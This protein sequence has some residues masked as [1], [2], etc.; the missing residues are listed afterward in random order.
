MTGPKLQGS[1]TL[2][3]SEQHVKNPLFYRTDGKAH[4]LRLAE[5][6]KHLSEH[7]KS[8]L[9]TIEEQVHNP[10]THISD[11]LCPVCER[12]FFEVQVDGK[13]LDYCSHCC[14]C[15][16][17]PTELKFFTHLEKDIPSEECPSRK[18]DYRCPICH[19]I[20]R[21]YTFMTPHVIFVDRCD[22]G[23]GLFLEDHA[24]D[25]VLEVC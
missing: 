23:H 18:S 17:Y 16:L 13:E 6:A 25:H 3:S 20:M 24:L 2:A 7:D 21:E 1:K 14:S 22:H 4:R 11:R 8:I 5:R 15:W 19:E 9:H 10:R 12:P